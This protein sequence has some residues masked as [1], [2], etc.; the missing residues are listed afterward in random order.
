MRYQVGPGSPAIFLAV[1][2]TLADHV[3]RQQAASLTV[4]SRDAKRWPN[5]LRASRRL[6]CDE[7]HSATDS[8]PRHEVKDN[9]LSNE[10]QDQRPHELRMTFA[11]SKSQAE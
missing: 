3:R 6:S 9:R 10:T 4:H 5:L 1:L 2:T 7:T 11:Y 8:T